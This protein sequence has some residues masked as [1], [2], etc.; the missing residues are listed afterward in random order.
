[1][2][3]YKIKEAKEKLKESLEDID[4]LIRRLNNI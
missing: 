2:R 1:M 3:H 4:R